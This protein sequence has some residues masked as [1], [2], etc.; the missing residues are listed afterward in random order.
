MVDT[1]GGYMKKE[2]RKVTKGAMQLVD[3]KCYAAVKFSESSADGTQKPNLEMLAYSG[4]IIKDHWY[5]GDL[6]IDLQG[7]NFPKDKFPILEDHDTSK[8]I[9]FITKMSIDGNQLT[10]LDATFV[11][12]PESLKFREN[13]AQGF[14]YEASIY[15][16]P[17]QIQTLQ[18]DE[19][20]EVNG[21]SMQGPG[22]IWRKSTFKESS[23][24][25]FG[26][27]SNTKSAAFSEEFDLEYISEVSEASKLNQEEEEGM[28]Y[29][30]FKTEH[31]EEFAKLA[32]EVTDGIEA[33]FAEEK[34]A[35]E[36][37]LA[38]VTEQNTKLTEETKLGEKRLLA[39]EKAEAIR[40]EAAL[41]HSADAVFAEKFAEAGLPERL[42]AK[43]RKMVSHEAFVAD[44]SFDKEAFAAA[45]DAELKDWSD[46]ADGSV[47]G[48]S[49]SSKSHQD[50]KSATALKACEDA[51]DR[52]LKYLK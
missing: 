23:V 48:F 32:K 17:T 6:A 26:Y 24:C 45:V 16:R 49:T 36:A 51:A 4:G 40:Q 12:S 21:F 39:L 25:T 46:S 47:L 22:T 35:L 31:P 30:K 42:S 34:T 8:K 13:S 28:N 20:A 27:D 52:M 10:V 44:G 41:K 43:V 11:D 9:G 15:A 14:P 1:I 2:T 38:S 37:Q 33:K 29:L 7:M 50:E 18:K 19:V 3:D 5:W